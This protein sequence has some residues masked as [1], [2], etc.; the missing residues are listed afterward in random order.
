[1]YANKG[2]KWFKTVNTIAFP[3]NALPHHNNHINM[4]L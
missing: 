1:M 2:N 4:I 3:E